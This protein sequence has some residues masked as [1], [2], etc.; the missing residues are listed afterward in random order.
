[1]CKHNDI[2]EHVF[3]TKGNKQQRFPH[4]SIVAISS[5]YQF[6]RRDKVA[7]CLKLRDNCACFSIQIIKVLGPAVQR[8]VSLKESSRGQWVSYISSTVDSEIF[9]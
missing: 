6:S 5:E 7:I 4:A 8:I 1:M 9:A 2:Y 3:I